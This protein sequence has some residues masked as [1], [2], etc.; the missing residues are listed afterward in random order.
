MIVNCKHCGGEV[1]KPPSQIKRAKNH[2]CCTECRIA[3]SKGQSHKS[4]A[5]K[6]E[7]VCAQC[8]KTKLIYP[9]RKRATNFCD[10]ICY[11]EW[12]NK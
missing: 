1:N 4:K 9:S 12:R 2:Y 3:G 6:I 10:L 11:S 7:V 8:G 5:N